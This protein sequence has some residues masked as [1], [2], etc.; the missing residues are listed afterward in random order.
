MIVGREG[1]PYA[2]VPMMKSIRT[3]A[4]ADRTAMRVLSSPF[5]FAFI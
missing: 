1:T 5:V 2:I 4:S 3:R